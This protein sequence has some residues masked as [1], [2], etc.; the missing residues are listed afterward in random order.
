MV[1]RKFEGV[2][3]RME[4]LYIETKSNYNRSYISKFMSDR[5]CPVCGGDLRIVYAYEALGNALTVSPNSVS[6]SVYG[7]D[8]SGLAAT[9]KEIVEYFGFTN[10]LYFKRHYLDKMLADGIL[11]MTIPEKPTSK[12]QKYYS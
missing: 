8:K 4:R 12:N 5:K 3:P 2:I 11:N 9:T 7:S 6:V 1:N 10:R